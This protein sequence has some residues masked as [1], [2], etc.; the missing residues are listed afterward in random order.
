LEVNGKKGEKY[1]KDQYY[2][3]KWGEIKTEEI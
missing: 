1:N 3:E 2:D